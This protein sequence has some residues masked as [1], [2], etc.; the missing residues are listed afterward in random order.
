M[1]SSLAPLSEH[2]LNA[3]ASLLARYVANHLDQWETWRLRV[4]GS[5]FDVAIGPATIDEP[6]TQVWPRGRPGE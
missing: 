5:D 3:L 4:E 1:P 2:D 6:A